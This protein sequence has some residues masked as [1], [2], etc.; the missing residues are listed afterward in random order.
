MFEKVP[1]PPLHI[2]ELWFVPEPLKVI[3]PS[4][5]Q[6]NWSVPAFTVG[7]GFTNTFWI[8]ES[9]HPFALVYLYNISK[10]PL[11]FGENKPVALIFVPL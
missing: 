2:N 6:I 5:A 4:V 9:T 11:A 1:N 7:L 10:V 3:V 8:E